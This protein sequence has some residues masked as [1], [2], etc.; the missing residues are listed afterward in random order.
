MDKIA[1]LGPILLILCILSGK[2]ALS[3]R[4]ET[5]RGRLRVPT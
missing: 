4:C 2:A 5:W 1:F 3:V